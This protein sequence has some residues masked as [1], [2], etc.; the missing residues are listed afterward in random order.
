MT[1]TAELRS[2]RDRPYELLRELDRRAR[3]AA[4][5]KPEAAVSAA[6][7]SCWPARKRAR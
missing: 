7:R 4:Q 3:S 1:G 2:L 6:R 5:G